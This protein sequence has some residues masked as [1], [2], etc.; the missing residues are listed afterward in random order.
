MTIMSS[1]EDSFVV[2]AISRAGIID[3]QTDVDD[4][5]AKDD[6]NELA[7]SLRGDG[8]GDKEGGEGR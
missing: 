6:D 4:E 1:P 3:I 7:T 2:R 8:E 5:E